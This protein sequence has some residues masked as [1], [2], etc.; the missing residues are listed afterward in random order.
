VV[1]SVPE[2]DSVITWDFDALKG[3]VAFAIYHTKQ[4]VGKMWAK[5]IPRI[6]LRLKIKFLVSGS[7]CDR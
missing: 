3:D 4:A 2:K 5:L 6:D 1:V 7:V